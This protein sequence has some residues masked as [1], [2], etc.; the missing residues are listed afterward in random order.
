M[1]RVHEVVAGVEAAVPLENGDV[2]ADRPEEAER[3]LLA[4]G[5]AGRFLDD[6][7]LDPADIPGQPLVEDRA[8]KIP[9]GFGRDGFGADAARLA[10]PPLDKREE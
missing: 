1:R 2:A 3:V 5:R 6:L 8:E 10:G 4:E 9:P 7:D